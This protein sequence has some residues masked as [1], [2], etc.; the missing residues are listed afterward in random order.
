M[1]QT[2]TDPLAGFSARTR[3]W[4]ERSFAAPTP[5]QAAGWPAIATG[6]NTLICAPTGSGKTL[7]AFLWGIDRLAREP[8]QLGSGVRLV[9]VSPLKALS[10]DVERNLRAPLA[11]TGAE[12][13]VGLRTG[14]T[15]QR[16][17]QAMLRKPPDILI[18]TPESLYLMMTS[19]AREI[20]TDV[21]ALIVDEI[22]AVAPTKRGAHMALTIERLERHVR[23]ASNEGAGRE[24]PL[25]RIGLS[26]TQRPLERIANFLVGPGRECTIVD[27]GISKE[28]DLEI[29]VPVEDMAQISTAASSASRP[30]AAAGTDLEDGEPQLPGPAPGTPQMPGDAPVNR[31]IWP[32]IY[33][34]LLRL[35]REHTSTIIFV[36]NRRG[37]ERLAKR[38]NEMNAE[39]LFEAEIAAVQ[40]AE[41]AS[42][43]SGTD[44]GPPAPPEAK[45]PVP[46]DRY[47]EIARA[48]HGSLAREE[49]QIVEELLKSGQLPCLVATSSLELG[50]DMGAVDLVIQ[51]ESPKSVAR[52]MQR[53]GRAGHD[54][55][56]VS[57]GRIF[58]KFRSDLLECAVVVK[59]MRTGEIEETVIPRNPLDVLAQHIVS[60]V[61]DEEWDVDEIER[62]VKGAEP[63]VD[64]SREQLENVLDMLDGRYPSERFAE[65]RPRLVW[66]R[67]AGTVR[68]RKGARQLAVTNAG[69]IPDRGLFGVHL[70]DGRRVG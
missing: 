7:A 15:P 50:I 69:T 54:L 33:P 39:E 20:L 51:V 12:V 34:E 55:G 4:F 37:S 25:Q 16:E 30:G 13:S 64:L 24:Q 14:D 18:T 45:P 57:K 9:Y 68:G 26:A 47:P 17:R 6:A 5:A 67:T 48:H 19:R 44:D 70:P 59:R 32:A 11:G 49:R 65:L 10:Y 31:G 40:P 60:M 27:A 35:V 58:P 23:V 62:V 46:L 61:A 38:L 1:T 56:A 36:N 66:D 2:T 3:G 41:A 53:V 22:H 52:G 63:Y 8:E 43:G 21:E 29:V 28:M 42:N